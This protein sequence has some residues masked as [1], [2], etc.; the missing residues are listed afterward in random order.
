MRAMS[1]AKKRALNKRET[2]G[3]KLFRTLDELKVSKTDFAK[4]VERSYVTVFRWGKDEDFGQE[5]QELAAAALGLPPD[6]FDTD[7]AVERRARAARKVYRDF[8]K[9]RPELA[10]ALSQEALGWLRS[11][12]FLDP[13]I[14]PSVAF[15][16]A[17]ASA[18]LGAIRPQDVLSV[19]AENAELDRRLAEIDRT[20]ADKRTPKRR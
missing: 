3:E 17:V 4:R 1:P 12:R 7:N 8:L 14:Q 5:Q 20:Q 9:A 19:A 11:F 18:M 16:E 10:A 13:T 15:F 6:Y 2:R